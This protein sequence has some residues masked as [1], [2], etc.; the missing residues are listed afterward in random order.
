[1]ETKLKDIRDYLF[2]VQCCFENI[3]RDEELKYQS[4]EIYRRVRALLNI[5]QKI[6]E[7]EMLLDGDKDY[8]KKYL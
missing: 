6:V 8:L 3:T 5:Y 1:M 2:I 7:D 4:K